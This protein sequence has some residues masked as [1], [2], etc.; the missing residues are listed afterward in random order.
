MLSWRNAYLRGLWMSVFLTSIAGLIAGWVGGLFFLLAA[1]FG[2]AL[3]EIVNYMEQYGM[4]RL[5]DQSVQ[6][7]HSWNTNSLISSWAMVN[8]SRHSH[9]HAQ[10]EVPYQDLMPLPEAPMMINGYLATMLVTLVSPVWHRMMI[11]KLKEWDRVFATPEEWVLA[12]RANQRSG[13]RALDGYDPR[14]W[15]LAA[16]E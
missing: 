14:D 11:P 2:K 13:L 4:V 16:E 8:L 1:F 9:H 3:L 5:P 15:S 6:P 10:G 12:L 7:R